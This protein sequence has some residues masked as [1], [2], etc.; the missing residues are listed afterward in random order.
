MP[1]KVEWLGSVQ[2]ALP[3]GKGNGRQAILDGRKWRGCTHTHIGT[4]DLISILFPSS[5]WYVRGLELATS[6]TAVVN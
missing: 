3:G 6:K 5:C 2:L 4:G 1:C